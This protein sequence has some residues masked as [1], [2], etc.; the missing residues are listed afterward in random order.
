MSVSGLERR[1]EVILRA[2]KLHDYEREYRFCE[3]RWRLDF[4]WPEWKVALEVDGETTHVRYYQISR[5]AAKRNA[6]TMQG[7]R[8]VI[9]T[10]LMV[11]AQP[12][13][14]LVPLASLLGR[15]L[16]NA[17]E[18]STDDSIYKLSK[19]KR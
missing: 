4:A 19:Y 7:W 16:S 10:G 1:V 2:Y 17:G 3:R 5:D 9:A 14:F 12:F 15:E 18:M 13:D 11:R 8:V 6:A